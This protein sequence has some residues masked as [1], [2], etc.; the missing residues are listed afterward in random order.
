MMVCMES[1]WKHVTKTDTCW[2][3]TGYISA[4][5]YG[6]LGGKGAHRI[7]YEHHIGPIPRGLTIDH[8]CG[9]KSCVNPVH[10]RIMSR[11]ANSSR[12]WQEQRTT[13]RN[14]HPWTQENTVERAG[15]RGTRVTLCRTCERARRRRHYHR[16]SYAPIM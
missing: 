7:S 5:G 2:L 4:K 8:S 11:S 12:Y 9:V 16:S 14:G 15:P 13:C 3:W 10:L 6:R 1:F